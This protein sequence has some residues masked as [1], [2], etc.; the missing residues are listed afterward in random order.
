MMK[1]CGTNKLPLYCYATP[2]I[3]HILLSLSQFGKIEKSHIDYVKEIFGNDHKISHEAYTHSG[4]VGLNFFENISDD[5]T[6][7]D[8]LNLLDD[9]AV[10][11]AWSQ[12]KSSLKLKLID[13]CSGKNQA[14]EFLKNVNPLEKKDNKRQN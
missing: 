6:L 5:N 12:F 3:F 8:C 11:Y 1:L 9:E 14:P 13:L 10:K 7:F 4:A 2:P